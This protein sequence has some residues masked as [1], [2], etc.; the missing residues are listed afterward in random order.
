[1][2]IPNHKKSPINSFI[3]S[4]YTQILTNIDAISAVFQIFQIGGSLILLHPSTNYKCSVKY[5][6]SKAAD[7]GGGGSTRNI[8]RS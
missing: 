1:M 8:S 4:C 7:A 5:L 6:H 2:T 3:S